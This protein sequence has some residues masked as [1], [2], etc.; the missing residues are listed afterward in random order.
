MSQA[1]RMFPLVRF[2]D[3]RSFE[4]AGRETSVETLIGPM[5]EAWGAADRLARTVSWLKQ[6]PRECYST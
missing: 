2:L 5:H 6:L 4:E 1:A 3:N